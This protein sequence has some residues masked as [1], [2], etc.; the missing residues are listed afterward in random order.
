MC[1]DSGGKNTFATYSQIVSPN[2]IARFLFGVCA[3]FLVVKSFPSLPLLLVFTIENMAI[4]KSY[5]QCKSDKTFH[6]WR[7]TMFDLLMKVAQVDD[8]LKNGN[9]TLV[10][11]QYINNEVTRWVRDWHRPSGWVSTGTLTANIL[12]TQRRCGITIP[13]PAPVPVGA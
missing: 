8:C 13:A 7:R 12:G 6:L 4:C 10:A 9:D 5:A 11:A 2:C 3:V 1:N